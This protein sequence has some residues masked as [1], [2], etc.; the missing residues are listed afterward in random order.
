MCKK[1]QLMCVVGLLLLLAGCGVGKGKQIQVE[2]VDVQVLE[3]QVNEATQSVRLKVKYS[4]DGVVPKDMGI[5]DDY[6]INSLTHVHT[7]EE[8]DGCVVVW[9][10]F[11]N[12]ISEIENLTLGSVALSAED[13]YTYPVEKID[14]VDAGS[15][16]LEQNG[17]N[18]EILVTPFTVTVT[19][20]GNWRDE[21]EF[22]NLIATMKDGSQAYVVSLPVT[23][24]RKPSVKEDD[25]VENES[26][27]DMNELGAGMVSGEVLD[28][29]GIKFFTY[30]DIAVDQIEKMELVQ[31]H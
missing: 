7:E 6:A 15:F 19:P 25:P 18:I 11:Y 20:K 2:G 10:G 3:A 17:T 27:T 9:E 28:Y 26:V 24:E 13:K 14:K 1:M 4:E 5:L 23:D 12:D 16:T 22:Y 29:D 30:E 8:K 31:Y 21:N